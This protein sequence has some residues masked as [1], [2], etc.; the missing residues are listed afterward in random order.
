MVFFFLAQLDRD[1]TILHH[2]PGGIDLCCI[3]TRVVKSHVKINCCYLAFPVL[4]NNSYSAFFL[5]II[6][7]PMYQH[8]HKGIQ[9]AAKASEP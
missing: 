5:Q 6:S 8:L 2:L 4:L 7:S 9:M 3:F 1:L